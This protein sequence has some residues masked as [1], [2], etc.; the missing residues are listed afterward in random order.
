MKHTMQTVISLF[1]A[2]LMLSLCASA[3]EPWIYYDPDAAQSVSVTVYRARVNEDC[4][5]S[6]TFSVHNAGETK[7]ENF[8]ITKAALTFG[9]FSLDVSGKVKG[10][11]IGAGGSKNYRVEIAAKD[12]PEELSD[13]DLSKCRYELTYSYASGDYWHEV[14]TAASTDAVMRR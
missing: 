7:A 13:A 1:F 9:E 6:I 4:S 10:K 12:V 8:S 3:S 5:L 14:T 11:N 2:V